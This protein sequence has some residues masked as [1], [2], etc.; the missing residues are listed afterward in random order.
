MCGF[1]VD[2][3][4]GLDLD[5][6]KAL[7]ARIQHRGPDQSVITDL[8]KGARMG[9][10]RLAIMDTSTAG[11]QPFHDAAANTFAVCNGEIYNHET[12]RALTPEHP[13]SSGSDCEVLLPLLAKFGIADMVRRLDGEFAFVLYDGTSHR[14]YAARD[15][16]GIRPLF[17]GF[18]KATGH[19]VLA[20]EAKAL[21][22][23]CSEIYPFPPGHYFDG[24]QFV[25]YCDAAAAASPAITDIDTALIGIRE[26]L[27]SAVQKRLAADVPVGFLLSGGLDSSLVCAIAAR[28]L[29]KP[30]ITFAT[31]LTENPIDIKYAR[32]VAD[33]I[34]SEHHEVLFTMDEVFAA[35]DDLIYLLETWDITTI[36]A[37]LGMFLV[38]RYVRQKTS[39]RV[40]LTGEVSD[41]IFGYK[42]TDFAPSPQAFQAEAQK[43]VHELYM[44][45]V[46]RA[47]R[48]IAGNSLEARVPF[49]D[50]D[51]VSHVMQIDP[52]LKMNTRQIGKYV[53]RAAFADGDWLPSEILWREKAAFSDAVGHGMVDQLKA[54][55]E[56]YYSDAEF[57]QQ[58]AHYQH[59]KPLS[60]EALYY[61]EIFEKHYPGRSKW[62]KSFWLPNQQWANCKVSD[63]SARALPNYG[64]SGQ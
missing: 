28:Q 38:S 21:H 45:D 15:P 39:V 55:A 18:E 22:D 61:R 58:S 59:G 10:H 17:Y 50:Q 9:F 56:N 20:S 19:I 62:I 51:F 53:L 43:R 23:A 8:P 35:L 31:G 37:S 48:C 44:Y 52:K 12:L 27:I 4:A 13:Y 29:N 24:A 49:S 2:T 41:E 6:F 26:H 16:I 54:F 1:L 34:G 60:K 7:F 63:P 3:G 5:R 30:L 47:D 25:R 46:L 57:A 36:R 40:L 11:Q 32:I 14:F 33:Y 64:A 42:Y